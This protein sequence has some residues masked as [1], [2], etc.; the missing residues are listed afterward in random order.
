MIELDIKLNG[1]YSWQLVVNDSSFVWVDASPAIILFL[2]PRL[3]VSIRPI[4]F[5]SGPQHVAC[6]ICVTWERHTIHQPPLVCKSYCHI[7]MYIL[8]ILEILIDIPPTTRAWHAKWDSPRTVCHKAKEE[9]LKL[10][11]VKKQLEEE[12]GTQSSEMVWYSGDD[13]WRWWSIP[14]TFT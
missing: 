11:K 8:R 3:S 2:Q 14:S 9:A 7:V 6:G 1:P 4:R 5:F 10:Q 12:V 13:W